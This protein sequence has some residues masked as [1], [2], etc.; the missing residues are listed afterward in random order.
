MS[1]GFKKKLSFEVVKG[2]PW[3]IS[4]HPEVSMARRFHEQIA[5]QEPV[6]SPVIEYLADVRK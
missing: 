4:A 1:K 3:L 6:S 5:G 2:L